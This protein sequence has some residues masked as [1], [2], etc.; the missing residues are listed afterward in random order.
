M[1]CDPG[2][3]QYDAAVIGKVF[4]PGGRADT[5][6][7]TSGN[8]RLGEAELEGISKGWSAGSSSAGSRPSWWARPCTRSCTCWD[9]MP[10]MCR[11]PRGL[12]RR[13][14]RTAGWR[15]QRACLLRLLGIVLFEA[16]DVTGTESVLAEGLR[17]P[18]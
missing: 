11:S 12:G 9:V 5:L 3:P 16:D 15:P 4:W 8:G 1:G 6:D 14:A 17:L 13:H 2:A 10:H 18:P 7:A